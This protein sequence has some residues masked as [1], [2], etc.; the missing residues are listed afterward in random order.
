MTIS[1]VEVAT[2]RFSCTSEADELSRRLMDRLG[3]GNHYIP[4]RLAIARSLAIPEPPSPAEGETARNIP[5]DTLF[6]TGP[7]LA[8][9]ISLLVEHSGREPTDKREFKK[10]VAAHW[11]RGLKLLNETLEQSDGDTSAFWRSLVAGLP[12]SA[13][14][15]LNGGVDGSPL[16]ASGPIVL[17]V[18]EVAQ[19]ALTAETVSW[20]LNVPAGSPHSAFMGGV[21]SGKTRTAA[22]MLR[23]IR[24]QAP[25]PMI[26]FDFKGDMSDDKNALDRAFEATVLAPP[27]APIPL[28]VF[29]LPDRTPSEIV[30]AA[31]RIRDSLG[32]LKT[33]KLQ[34]NQKRRLGDALEQA[35]RTRTPCTL[36]D[37]RDALQQV[38]AAQ[39]AREDGAV[40]TLVD[41][42]RLPLFEPK[43][44][45]AEFFSRSWIIS[46]RADVPELVRVSIVILLTDTLERYI[47]SLPEAPVDAGGNRALRVI[48]VIDEAHKIL[49]ARLPGLSNLIRLS[50]SKGGAV[51]LISQRPDDFDGEDDDLLSEMGL[52]ACF[53]TNAKEAAARRIL[54]QGASLTV[55]KPGE[56]WVKVRGD[57]KARRVQAWR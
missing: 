35:L 24:Q 31:Q 8:A 53:G 11:T 47:N 9:W 33:T 1:L 54:G 42:C 15:P 32:N 14:S 17:P 55:L 43:M 4:A 26:A 45:P 44:S 21:G 12:T 5:G 22:F 46:L 7:D 38:Y 6:G 2:E 40:N 34:D 57:Q 25:V 37:V 48:C 27:D 30:K 28:D 10:L 19:D 41:L 49:G 16:V 18:G 50:R 52:I 23:A 3:L 51:M 20:G 36:T 13:A 39:N 56:A 29:W